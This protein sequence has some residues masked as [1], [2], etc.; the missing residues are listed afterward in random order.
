MPTSTWA[1]GPNLQWP[2]K[3]SI[4]KQESASLETDDCYPQVSAVLLRLAA[5]TGDPQQDT[6]IWGILSQKE[7]L[8]M[9]ITP[10]PEIPVAPT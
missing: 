10:S 5:T 4:T 9:V 7:G 8:G 1:E 2:L 6:A 3:D